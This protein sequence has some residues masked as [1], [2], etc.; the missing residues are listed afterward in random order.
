MVDAVNDVLQLALARSGQDHAVDTRALQVLA[1]A[2]GVTPY[3]GVVHQQGVLNAVLGVIHLGR[4]LRVDH[5]DQVAV[6]S[7]G[8][9]GF[10]D[11]DGAIERAMYRVTTQQ[12]G[13]L[14]QIV[15]G[16]FAHD[17][18]TQAQAVAT[19][20]FFDQDARQQTTDTT[21]AVQ[22]NVSAFTCRSILLTH[23]IGQ[24]FAYKLL[25]RA[26]IAFGL[27]LHGQLAQVYRGS[28]ELE[29]AHCL[30]QRESFVHGQFDVIGLTMASKAVS[31]E[32][33]ND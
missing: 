4:V 9:V 30:E 27:E 23:Y 32:N 26:A 1:Q 5:L 25:S 12:A 16:A 17:D 7:D 3:T 15:V 24:F 13:T 33:R 2:V 18:G 31:L 21:E 11:H 19:T 10:I 29:L 8:V 20:G 14:D 28:A 22:H 6:G